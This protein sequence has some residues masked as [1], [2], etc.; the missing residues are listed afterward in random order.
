MNSGHRHIFHRN[1][2]MALAMGLLVYACANRGYPEGGPKDE[3][4]PEVVAEQPLSFSTDFKAKRVNIYFN[5]FVQLKEINEKFIFSPPVKKDPKVSLRGKYVQIAMPDS[6]RPNTTYSM[7]F[8][9]AIVD[10]NEGNPLG[11]YRYVFSTG[12]A[13]DTLELSGKVVNAESGEPMMG[14]LVALYERLGDSVPL[15]E[16]PDYIARTD[17]AGFF[18]VTNLREADYRVAAIED[19]N[20]DKMYTPEAEWFGWLDSTVHPVVIPVTQTDT[21]RLV[22]RIEGQD[23]LMRDS[24]VT[25]DLLAYGP[26]NLYLRMFQE[27]PTQLYLVDDERKERERLDFTFSIPAENGFRA[28]LWDTLATEPLPEG[29]YFKED[30]PG[31]DTIT[32]WIKDS[33]VYKRDTL[34]LILHYLRSD[35]TGR[36]SAYADTSRYTFTDKKTKEENNRKRDGGKEKKQFLDIRPSVSSELELGTRLSLEFDRP[37]D[38]A[39]LDSIRL[40]VK[41]DTLWVPAPFRLAED[42]AKVRRVFIDAEWTQGGEYKLDIDSAS[43]FDIYGRS[44]NGLEKKFKV[45]TE[46][47]YGKILLQV[48][49]VTQPTILQLYRSE[50][51]KSENGKR[52]YN[53]VREKSIDRDGEAVFDLLK[54]GKYKF[55]AILDANGNGIWDTGLYLKGRQPEEIIYL[56]VE[57]SVRPNFDIEQTFDL[58]NKG[59]DT[60]EPQKE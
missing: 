1:G 24:I 49:G 39:T 15:K 45:K 2:W 48:H 16:L 13:I 36:H 60:P 4:P 41:S 35:S 52:K 57:I 54:E 53:V 40:S 6:L 51:G 9:D 46:E 14:L 5:E 37:I 30:S 50:G 27:K 47:Q 3:T 32:L 29:W 28:E 8:A 19:A 58:Q 42:S 17:S 23:T 25:R 21:F 20:R 18:R 10:N 33:T 26:G 11:F 7:D 34:Y 44:N 31:H 55:R 38:K 43:V 56:P 59:T 22:E 12:T